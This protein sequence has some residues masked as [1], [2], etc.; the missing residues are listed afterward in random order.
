MRAAAAGGGWLSAD[1]QLS[2]ASQKQQRL[3]PLILNE[4]PLCLLSRHLDVAPRCWRWRPGQQV[5]FFPPRHR[6]A[7][8]RTAEICG[9]ITIKPGGNTIA[10]PGSESLGAG[11]S[12]TLRRDLQSIRAINGSARA[13]VLFHEKNALAASLRVSTRRPGSFASLRRGW[14]LL[15]SLSADFTAL[16]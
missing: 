10:R 7:T 2:I 1:S 9:G 11:Q 6:Q 14:D 15:C 5:V 12:F 4:T 3:C 16:H 8:R 13:N